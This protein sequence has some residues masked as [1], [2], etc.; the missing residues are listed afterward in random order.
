MAKIKTG[1]DTETNPLYVKV[2]PG[3]NGCVNFE[4]FAE[5]ELTMSTQLT[6]EGFPME[7]ARMCEDLD[8]DLMTDVLFE[9]T[10]E[11]KKGFSDMDMAEA[12]VKAF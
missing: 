9:G 7:F 4:T 1:V 11:L 5:G 8:L 2:S 3:P 12:I 10:V 6:P